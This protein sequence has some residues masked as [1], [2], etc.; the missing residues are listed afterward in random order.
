MKHGNLVFISFHL[1]HIHTSITHY[2]ECNDNRDVNRVDLTGAHD[3]KKDVKEVVLNADY[4]SFYKANMYSNFGDL[5]I[6]VKDMLETYSKTQ[7][8]H[9]E[10]SSIGA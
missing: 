1:I 10:V 4:D 7:K 8:G 6:A 9:A 5:G 2:C 3:A